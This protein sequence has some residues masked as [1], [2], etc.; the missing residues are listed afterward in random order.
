MIHHHEE[1]GDLEMSFKFTEVVSIWLAAKG[2]SDY[3]VHE[4]ANVAP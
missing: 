2:S 3:N 4:S 1:P